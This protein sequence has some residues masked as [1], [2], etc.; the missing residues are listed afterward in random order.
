MTLPDASP[1]ISE[2]FDLKSKA[3]SPT[4]SRCFCFFSIC[5]RALE[6]PHSSFRS[7]HQGWEVLP[8][9]LALSLCLIF[10]SAPPAISYLPCMR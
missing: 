10:F 3:S 1:Q 7:L 8:P 5:L 6:C 9:P 4:F 2:S